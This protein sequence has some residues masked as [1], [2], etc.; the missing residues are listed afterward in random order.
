MACGLFES[1]DPS[2]TV[3]FEITP[4]TR[5]AVT[6]WIKEA[7]LASDDFLFPSRVH[8][9]P[10]LGSEVGKSRDKD[11]DFAMLVHELQFPAS[12]N[13]KA[14]A[15]KVTKRHDKD[16][17]SVVFSTYHSIDVISQAQKLH[18]L[19]DFDLIICDEAHR[20]TGA[21]LTATMNLRLSKSTTRTSSEAKNGFT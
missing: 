20:T 9:S 1:S 5:E 4:P 15:H 16:H 14:L 17:M 11:D 13:P 3:L 7:E 10:H 12:T 18:G 21:S 6:D 19:A 2:Q 8:D